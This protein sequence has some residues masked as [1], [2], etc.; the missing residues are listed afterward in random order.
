MITHQYSSLLFKLAL[1]LMLLTN[2][3][4]LAGIGYNRWGEA[5]SN[6]LLSQ[7]ELSKRH[8][9]AAIG[10]DQL[11]RLRWQAL[12]REREG[13]FRYRSPLWL[14]AKKLTALGFDIAAVKK[15]RANDDRYADIQPRE[16]FL[17][18]ELAGDSYQQALARNKKEQLAAE[19]A[20]HDNPDNPGSVARVRERFSH[21]RQAM[22]RLF[23][24]DAGS[25]AEVL[26]QQYADKERFL[27]MKGLVNADMHSSGSGNYNRL[28][29][30]E[31]VFGVIQSLSIDQVHLP[32]ELQHRVRGKETYELTLK[33]G[34]RFEP[35]I[36]AP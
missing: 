11:L 17:V 23:V 20:I 21:L 34:Q 24:I 30:T 19:Q 2:A 7:R 8:A 9:Y 31:Q 28:F 22:S 18:L 16:V 14:N 3:V 13:Y 25:D 15:R 10:E 27:I 6:M 36:E 32:V 5:G 35:W 1:V 4:V 26:R 12:E 33:V 29:R